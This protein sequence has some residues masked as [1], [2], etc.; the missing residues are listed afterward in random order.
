MEWG[1]KD[2]LFDSVKI[3]YHGAYSEGTDKFPTAYGARFSTNPI[4]VAY[5]NQNNSA[6]F[7]YKTLDGTN[8]LN[9]S[10]YGGGTNS[11]SPSSARD[12]EYSGAVNVTI[13]FELLTPAG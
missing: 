8:L 1:G 12:R 4:P 9:Q 10:I 6:D 13:P 11:D 3:D 5:N 2:V 7:M